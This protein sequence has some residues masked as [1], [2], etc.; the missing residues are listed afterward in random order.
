MPDKLMQSTA[1]AAVVVLI[2]CLFFPS[3]S[4][5]SFQI[6]ENVISTQNAINILAPA[7]IA[8]MFIE[9]AVEIFVISIRKNQKEIYEIALEEESGNLAQATDDDERG[10]CA[11]RIDILNKKIIH[12]KRDTTK[13]STIFSL[14]F[15][16]LI[17]I[18]GIRLLAPFFEISF[19][20]CLSGLNITPEDCPSGLENL[21]TSYDWFVR[22]DIFISTFVI[23]GGAAGIHSIVDAITSFA[24]RTKE[25]N[26][27]Q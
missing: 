2:V 10:K 16:L 21:A 4:G 7:F 6:K 19:L 8:A 27:N 15:S 5:I 1:A 14:F 25:A 12:Y 9:R 22:L 17:A 3:F 23:A 24:D 18:V 13:L 11:K 26:Q 20:D